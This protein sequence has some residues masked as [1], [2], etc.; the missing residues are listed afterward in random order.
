MDGTFSSD[1]IVRTHR[2]CSHRQTRGPRSFIS[3]LFLVQIF[4]YPEKSLKTKCFIVNASDVPS[5]ERISP[6]PFSNQHLLCFFRNCYQDICKQH[7]VQPDKWYPQR[8]SLLN[9]TII[10]SVPIRVLGLQV[11]VGLLVIVGE[12]EQVKIRYHL[13]LVK[14][15]NCMNG[16]LFV[17]GFASIQ[18]YI[19]LYSCMDAYVYITMQSKQNKLRLYVTC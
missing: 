4:G 19:Q 16:W 18:I 17:L 15:L 14:S 7:F 1:L 5:N 12:E 8:Q 3:A 6:L 2:E 13:Y 10:L 9:G 11:N